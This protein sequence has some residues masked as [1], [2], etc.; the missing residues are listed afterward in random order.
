M[1]IIRG[2]PLPHAPL[3]TSKIRALGIHSSISRVTTSKFWAEGVSGLKDFG[4]G[5]EGI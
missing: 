4:L 3:S 5:V 1:K 2:D